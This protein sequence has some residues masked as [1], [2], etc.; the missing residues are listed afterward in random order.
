MIPVGIRLDSNPQPG[1]FALARLL[2]VLVDKEGRVL[3][4][5]SRIHCSEEREEVKEKLHEV[6]LEEIL[7]KQAIQQAQKEETD[8][9]RY[10]PTW[11]TGRTSDI[12][13]PAGKCSVSCC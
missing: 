6:S 2:D 8:R 10:T 7:E 4:L 11:Q 3:L 13:F 5:K 12:P 1:Y 9:L